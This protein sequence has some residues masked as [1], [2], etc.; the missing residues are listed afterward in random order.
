MGQ[1]KKNLRNPRS[2]TADDK[3]DMRGSRIKAIKTWADVEHDSEDEFMENRDIISLDPDERNN[4]RVE[5]YDK[6][7]WGK[8]KHAYYDADE[9]S[10]FDDAKE[11]EEE[12]LR[13]QKKRIS[14]MTEED[15]VE[16][17]FFAGWS[18]GA[19]LDKDDENDRQLI[20]SV[21][22]D[23]KSISSVNDLQEEILVLERN[24]A[25]PDEIFKV[26]KN[27]SPELLELANE[28][29]EKYTATKEISSI[30]EKAK[31]RNQKKEDDH[32]HNFLSLKYQTL[33]N[34]LMNISFYFVLKSSATPR[35]WQHPV[36]NALLEIRKDLD[37]LGEVEKKMQEPIKRYIKKVEDEHETVSNDSV[38][39]RSVIIN[40]LDS[41]EALSLKSAL[42]SSA[43]K[44]SA[45]PKKVVI[46]SPIHSQGEEED[47]DDF[48]NNNNNIGLSPLPTSKTS[49]LLLEDEFVSLQDNKKKKRKRM[50]SDL[51]DL[52]VMDEIDAEEKAQKKSSLRQYAAKIDQNAS[53]RLK[54]NRYTGDTDIPY[55]GLYRNS[56]MQTT[57][58]KPNPEAELDDLDWDEADK[59]DSLE[60]GSQDSNDY[61]ETI[62]K[63]TESKKLEK[64]KQYDAQKE[65]K[66]NNAS[67]DSNNLPEGA[68]RQIN[69]QI[70]KNKGLTPH[71]NKDQRNPR[72]KHRKKY[73]KA[74]KKIKS[75]KQ[76]VTSQGGAYGGE[77]TGIKIGLSRSIKLS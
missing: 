46:I 23:L 3:Y 21:N 17:E 8:S 57:R 63:A 44:K 14:K 6:E 16:K 33:I 10:D 47:D 34:Y 69:Y 76:V 64:R 22:Q 55:K 65:Q 32:V 62:K 4:Q 9:L 58:K 2:E 36:F 60:F 37:K 38:P 27:N 30:L 43:S 5:D 18:T 7:T 61:Y 45:A 48:H 42:K 52:D 26:I 71:R 54:S 24:N 70:L 72:V 1:K 77:K 13:L 53:K 12:A 49:L 67:E 50:S 51:G 59:K 29:R 20:E 31:E 40:A 28:F 39:K 41:T 19:A 15:F 73:E 11:E 66:R 74:K 25:S 68:K 75:V 35:L 56:N